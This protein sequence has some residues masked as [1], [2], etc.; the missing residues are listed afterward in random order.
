LASTTFTP[1]SETP[2]VLLLTV[3]PNDGPAVSDTAQWTSV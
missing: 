1:N 3:T 2:Y